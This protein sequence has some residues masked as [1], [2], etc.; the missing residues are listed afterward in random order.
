MAIKSIS[1]QA[2]QSITGG[3]TILFEFGLGATPG[4]VAVNDETLRI[5]L[6]FNC[7]FRRWTFNCVASPTGADA[8]VDIFLAGVSIFDVAFG[9]KAVFPN[10]GSGLVS[11]SSFII[12]GGNKD[13]LVYAKVLQKGSSVS[14]K[15]FMVAL[16]IE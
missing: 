7:T 8:V 6:P 11:G 16:E 3:K 15:G 5:G 13:Q 1:T 12:S 2:G 10:G 9:T 4:D 14:G